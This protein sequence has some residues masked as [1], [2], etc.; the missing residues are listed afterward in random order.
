MI[1]VF[2]HDPPNLGLRCHLLSGGSLQLY[3]YWKWQL[4]K[5]THSPNRL[6]FQNPSWPLTCPSS[7]TSQPQEE[8]QECEE[9]LQ[10]KAFVHEDHCDDRDR[11]SNTWFPQRLLGDLVCLLEFWDHLKKGIP[12]WP[13][14]TLNNT[15]NHQLTLERRKW[16]FIIYKKILGCFRGLGNSSGS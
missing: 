7:R 11:L 6:G 10:H 12:A 9:V 15:P 14:N 5:K 1:R 2:Y 4:L 8:D 13:L 16:I 3:V